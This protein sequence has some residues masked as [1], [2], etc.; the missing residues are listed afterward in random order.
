M[1]SSN[2]LEHFQERQARQIPYAG[3]NN[4]QDEGSQALTEGWRPETRVNRKGIRKEFSDSQRNDQSD[5]RPLNT[6]LEEKR[7]R[8][9]SP[10]QGGEHRDGARDFGS[11]DTNR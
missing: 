3:S 5:Q 6:V 10:K 7:A 11:I 8:V 2:I 4:L 1:V 9:F